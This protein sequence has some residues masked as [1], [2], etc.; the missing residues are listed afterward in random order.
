MKIEIKTVTSLLFVFFILTSCGFHLR[1]AYKLPSDMKVTYVES[2]NDA[3]ALIRTLKRSLKSSGITLT[4]NKSE[5]LAVLKI[6]NEEQTKRVLSVDSQGR[7]QEYE[8]SY[9]IKFAVSANDSDFEIAEQSLN[10]QRDFLFDTE[11]VLG[12]GREEDTLIKDMQ[13]DI[14]RLLMLRLQSQAK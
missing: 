11:D 10:I 2:A 13:V 3:S 1:G 14:V 4:E 7:A 9:A 6:Y 5:A 8:L 12:K